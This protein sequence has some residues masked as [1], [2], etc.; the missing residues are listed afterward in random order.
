MTTE[1]TE[2]HSPSAFRT[3][4]GRGRKLVA[5]LPLVLIA[6]GG[7]YVAVRMATAPPPASSAGGPGVVSGLPLDEVISIGRQALRNNKPL[8]A[9]Q[10]LG[11]GVERFPNDQQ[12]RLAY[13]ESLIAVGK[14]EEAYEQYDR[15]VAVGEDRAEY[16]FAA[17][18]AASQAKLLDQAEAQWLRARELD[19]SNPQ[20]PLY[21][22]QLQ[23]KAG[24]N[25]DARANLVT[26][27]QL[28]PNLAIGWGTLAAI[29]LDENHTG[30]ALQHVEKS[31][32]L[33]PAL[34]LWRVLKAKILRRENRPREALESVL[35]VPEFERQTD[36][37]VVDELAACYGMLNQPAEAAAVCLKA[38]EA[39]PGNAELNYQAALWLQRDGQKDRA[40]TYA[41][42]ASILGKR[43]AKALAESLEASN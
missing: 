34:A 22:A 37:A 13:A 1:P 30:P 23:R 11:E 31:I 8:V 3:A 17:G 39:A 14:F 27:V 35:V 15:A 19:R 26:A 25:G 24:R 36:I 28:D 42:Q 20:Y 40:L 43:E 7:M 4:S 10:T 41:K 21:L 12:L 2:S 6:A 32:K 16:R 18:M 5:L 9:E 29:A 33:E 38:L